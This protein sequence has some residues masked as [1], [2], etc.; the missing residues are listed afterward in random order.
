MGSRERLRDDKT[1]MR[2]PSS[3]SAAQISLSNGWAS[4]GKML[5][6]HSAPLSAQAHPLST[7]PRRSQ[8]NTLRV[9]SKNSAPEVVQ[10][11]QDAYDAWLVKRFGGKVQTLTPSKAPRPARCDTAPSEDLHPAVKRLRADF[12]SPTL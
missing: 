12:E 11:V 10:A 6:Q 3:G 7:H 5:S 8:E 1:D 2:G 4:R 9:Y